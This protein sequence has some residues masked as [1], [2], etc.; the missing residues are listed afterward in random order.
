[1][2]TFK[3]AKVGWPIVTTS[4]WLTLS[5]KSHIRQLKETQKIQLFS[6]PLDLDIV[7][8]TPFYRQVCSRSE[9]FESH[10]HWHHRNWKSW[11]VVSK[12]TSS[13]S[14]APSL[15]VVRFSMLMH[16]THAI[17]ES[18]QF[19]KIRNIKMSFYIKKLNKYSYFM[20]FCIFSVFLRIVHFPENHIICFICITPE[21]SM[22][23]D[24]TAAILKNGGKNV[25]YWNIS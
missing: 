24:I 16:K 2:D 17:L 6:P 23:Y 20:W 25:F 15:I 21:N 18:V 11:K 22:G 13:L 9:N 14:R 8:K 4:A 1:M 5:S 3:G 10:M 7:L 12:K 19:A